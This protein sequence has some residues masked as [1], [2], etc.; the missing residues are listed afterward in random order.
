VL[1]SR[2]V[3]TYIDRGVEFVDAI[4]Q[5][6]VTRL[7][8]VLMTSLCTAFGALPLML[9]TGCGAR[10]LQCSVSVRDIFNPVHEELHRNEILEIDDSKPFSVKRNLACARESICVQSSDAH[11]KIH[12]VGVP[13]R[14][15]QH[16]GNGIGGVAMT[17]LRANPSSRKRRSSS[18]ASPGR[19]ALNGVGFERRVRAALFQR[20]RAPSSAANGPKTPRAGPP[21]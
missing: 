11:E 4:V 7:R 2:V 17:Q 13:V 10:S 3:M 18:A 5:A 9:A 16:G 19:C 15:R 12:A 21:A 14:E 1:G 6:S 8:P 20:G